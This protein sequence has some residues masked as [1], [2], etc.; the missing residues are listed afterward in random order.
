MRTIKYQVI[1]GKSMVQVGEYVYEAK[2]LGSILRVLT[3]LTDEEHA[4]LERQ[5][6]ADSETADPV[7]TRKVS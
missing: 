2:W 4:E 6:L 1:D 5:V 3:D 7:T